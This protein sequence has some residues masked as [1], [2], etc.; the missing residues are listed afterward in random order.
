MQ[1]AVGCKIEK[2]SEFVGIIIESKHRVGEVCFSYGD[3]AN[4]R[5]RV[6]L[7]VATKF[8]AQFKRESWH[9]QT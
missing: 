9:C 2:S 6:N 4:G 5:S 3:F 8:Q 1:F 7:E